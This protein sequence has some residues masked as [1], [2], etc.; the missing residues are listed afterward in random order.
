MKPLQINLHIALRNEVKNEV[1][2][3]GDMIKQLKQENN[4]KYALF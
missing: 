1:K 3:F 4:I 2:N